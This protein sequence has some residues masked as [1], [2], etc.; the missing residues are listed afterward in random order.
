MNRAA[1]TLAPALLLLVA[2]TGSTETRPRPTDANVRAAMDA[3]GKAGCL[4]PQDVRTWHN[5]NDGALFVDAGRRK[6]RVDLWSE[7]RDN[8]G[9]SLAFKGDSITGRVC[10]NAGDKVIT[11]S[12]SSTRE[13]CRIRAV[14]IIDDE[15]YAL[16]TGTPLKGGDDAS[17]DATKSR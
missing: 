5:T 8:L 7:C 15:T 2:C 9:V 12:V 10:G 1:F 6:Y 16:G 11:G 4:Y 14:R 17:D 13:E 3:K